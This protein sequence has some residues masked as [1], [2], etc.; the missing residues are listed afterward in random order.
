MCNNSC[1]D[2]CVTIA[3]FALCVCVFV[4]IY[5]IT[6]LIIGNMEI[7]NGDAHCTGIFRCMTGVGCRCRFW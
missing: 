1:D 3:H 4:C 5:L 6:S 2:N 7:L